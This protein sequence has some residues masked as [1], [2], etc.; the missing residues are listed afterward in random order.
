[1]VPVTTNQ[2]ELHIDFA[3]K[4]EKTSPMGATDPTCS[5]P[6]FG[7]HKDLVLIMSP[8]DPNG[9]GDMVMVG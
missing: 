9:Y 7:I 8:Y 3:E 4:S 5:F 6:T 2:D 1:M